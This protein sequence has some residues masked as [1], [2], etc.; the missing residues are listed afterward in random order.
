MRHQPP[1]L[2]TFFYFILDGL[3]QASDRRI[4][5]VTPADL[6]VAGSPTALAGAIPVVLVVRLATTASRNAVLH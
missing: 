1:R 5:P 3:C 2:G 6:A 4:Q